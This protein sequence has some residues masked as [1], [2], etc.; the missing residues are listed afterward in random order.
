MLKSTVLLDFSL[1]KTNANF[2]AIFIARLMSVLGIGML[3]VAVPVQIYE[4][5]GSSL[6]VGF[7]VALDG[8]GMFI[9]L[10]LGGV[11]ADRM[12][13]K[14]LILFSRSICGVGFVLLAANAYLSEPSLWAV[15]AISL[16][17]GFFSA[18][19]MTALMASIPYLV[20]RENLPTAG[21]LSMLV[22][23][24]GLVISPAVAGVV[25]VSF[26]VTWNYTLAAIGTFCT[27]ITLI[28]LPNMKPQEG[29]PEEHP[30]RSLLDGFQFVFTHKI[31][32]A[33]V[34]LGTLEAV[35]KSIRILFP[36][37]AATAFGGGAFEV[38]LMYAAM[39][40]GSTLGALTSGWV[41]HATRPGVVM[42]VTAFLSFLCVAA[43][44]FMGHLVLMLL[45]LA[46]FGYLGSIGGLLQYTIV[47]GH[48]PDHMLGRIGSFWTAQD[49]VGDS[50]GALGIGVIVK[51]LSPVMGL[52]ALGLG[53]AAATL[54]LGA[55]VRSL[56]NTALID[57]NL[58]PTEDSTANSSKSV[59]A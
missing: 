43:L 3:N 7:A 36:A 30:I 38:G 41:R 49:V 51:V 12:D 55:G 42:L 1:L 21:A 58:F 5:T 32:R 44:G 6:Q 24:I 48:T 39:P 29:A 18:I 56:R 14:W 53:C 2:R 20:G 23:R 52:A 45:A 27:L 46:I 15:Y 10:M 22:V 50:A 8:I 47:Q 28:T 26:G 25:I 13:R 40:V 9:G 57:T 59:A 17:D 37:L 35:T 11:L 16:W 54:L 19:G 33:V 34:A 4:L 31:I